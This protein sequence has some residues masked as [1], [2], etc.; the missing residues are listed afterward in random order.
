MARR[1]A[2][3]EEEFWREVGD[4]RWGPGVNEGERESHTGSGSVQGGPWAEWVPFGLFLFSYFF[5]IS[6]S[7][8]LNYFKSFI[9]LLQF[10]SNKLLIFF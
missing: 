6:F 10:K 3:Q 8:F 2:M 5:S 9:N 1:K 4:D 7:D